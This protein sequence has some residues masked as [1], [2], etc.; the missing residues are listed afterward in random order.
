[1][2]KERKPAEDSDI[3]QAQFANNLDFFIMSHEGK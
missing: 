1:M 2:Y 3:L